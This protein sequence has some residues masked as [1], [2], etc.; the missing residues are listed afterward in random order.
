MADPLV[1]PSFMRKTSDSGY[2]FGSED[3]S[4]RIG[5]VEKVHKPSDSTNSNS[6]ITEYDVRVRYGNSTGSRTSILYPK[7]R[8]MSTFGGLTDYCRWAPR[9][10]QNNSDDIN[11]NNQVLLLCVNGN[12]RESY[13][14]GGIPHSA[15]TLSDSEDD[16]YFDWEYN[17]VHV[18]IN[19]NGEL[20]IRRKGAT[21]PDGTVTDAE[22]HRDSMINLRQ[23][24]DI[25]L[26]TYNAGNPL[27]HAY[28]IVSREN[29]RLLGRA[30]DYIAFRTDDRFI[31]NTTAGVRI[32]PPGGVSGSAVVAESFLAG[33]TY[34]SEQ[35]EMHRTIQE[36]LITL[37]IQLATA[38]AFLT[39]A[40]VK[41]SIQMVGGALAS[42]DFMQAAQLIINMNQTVTQLR[43]AF[44]QFEARSNDY[45]SQ[46]HTFGG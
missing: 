17:G 22:N 16:V 43:T 14:I 25:V 35:Q 28:F 2:R 46:L 31:I 42:S 9:L 6:K 12:Q 39:T 1:I 32:N 3:T 30:E 23:N 29:Q 21:D 18:N 8:V 38:G 19:A 34:R 20:L 37:G 40:S 11:E 41:N 33:S 13:I 7:V 4:L 44:H 26:G 15:S 27:D 24:G 5:I 45:L 36:K 10:S